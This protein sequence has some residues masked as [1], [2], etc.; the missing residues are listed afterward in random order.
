MVISAQLRD[1]RFLRD[2]VN[3]RTG[4]TAFWGASAFTFAASATVTIVWCGWIHVGDGRLG[5]V[6]GVDADAGQTWPASRSVISR[7]VASDDG[8]DDAAVRGS[9]AASGG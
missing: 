2:R 7:R 8:D 1:G 5:H 9:H 4:E 3:D 6:D